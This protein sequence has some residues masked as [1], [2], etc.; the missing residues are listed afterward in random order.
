MTYALLLMETVVDM[1][2]NEEALDE[3]FPSQDTADPVVYQLVRVQLYMP[4]DE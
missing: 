4:V 2:G 3:E 1:V